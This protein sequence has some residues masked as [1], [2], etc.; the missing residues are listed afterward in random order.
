MEAKETFK[1][2]KGAKEACIISNSMTAPVELVP[3]FKIGRRANA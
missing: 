3:Q 2:F 1:V